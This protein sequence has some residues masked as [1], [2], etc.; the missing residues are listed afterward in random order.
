VGG[1]SLRR[2]YRQHDLL[3]SSL[4]MK[5][6]LWMAFQSKEYGHDFPCSTIPVVDFCKALGLKTEWNRNGLEQIITGQVSTREDLSKLSLVDVRNSPY[7]TPYIKC[8]SVFQTLSEKPVGGACFG[9]LT[10]AGA[11]L[12]IEK[13][14]LDSIMHPAF[15]KE[16]VCIISEKLW[17][18]AMACEKKGADFFWIAEPVAV[19]ISPTAFRN[20]SG[21][22]IKKIFTSISVPGF[23][24]I[25]GNTNYLLNELVMTGAQCLSL[26]SHVDARDA[27]YKLPRDVVVLGNINAI[28]MLQEPLADIERQVTQLNRAIRNFPNFI[29]SSGGGLSP[30]T[31][32][33]AIRLLFSVTGRFPVWSR[34]EYSQ[35][36]TLWNSLIA[37]KEILSLISKNRFS[38]AVIK[39]AWEEAATC[40]T[41]RLKSKKMKTEE[42]EAKWKNLMKLLYSDIMKNIEIVDIDGSSYNKNQLS[43]DLNS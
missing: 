19:M 2:F 27:V 30:E 3:N 36:D 38:S 32:E 26:D 29:I 25:P 28:S 23:L 22:Y 11:I 7:L 15:L 39:A 20:F 13:L 14:C 12:G 40:L 6:A 43:H 1:G 17:V 4:E 24:H 10:L 34:I 8:V 9:P 37:D 33:E 16:I 5:K 18:M 41:R 42:V 35:I 31:P 21:D